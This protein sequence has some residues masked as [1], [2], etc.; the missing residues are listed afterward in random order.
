M[1]NMLHSLQR[2]SS[3]EQFLRLALMIGAAATLIPLSLY[4]YLGIFSRYGSDDYCI[5]AFYLQSNLFNA[6]IQRYM[7]ATSRYTNI[8]FTGL[9]DKLLGWYNVAIL[10][11]LMLAL[12][13][14]GLYLL[15]REIVEMLALRW[16]RL[17][18]LFLSL[19]VVY[20]SLTQAPNLYETL[21][22]RAGM[23]SHLAPLVFIPFF[24]AFLLR[25]VRRVQESKQAPSLWILVACFLIPLAIGGLSEPPTALMIT[26]LFLALLAAWWW[27]AV[28]ARRS[29][30]TLLVC[31]L[32]GASVALIIM[33]LAP[34][35]AIR[36]ETAT[37][38]L[39]ELVSR[40]IYYPFYFILDT[41]R[42]FPVPTLVSIILPTLLF[43]VKYTGTSQNLSRE[44]RVRL[45]VLIIV[46]LLL[47]Y[48][49]IAAGFAPSAYGQSYPVPRARFIGR[50][51]M[52]MAL[53]T[54]G[55]LLGILASQI[56]I[57]LQPKVLHGFATFALALLMIYPLRTTARTFAEIPVYQERA[58]AW[59][60]RESE[61]K[62]LKAKGET[63]LVVRF[64][65]E[66]R[67]QD[68]GDHRGF[69]LN[70]CAAA[71]YGVNSI[72]AVPMPDK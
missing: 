72:V 71:L 7:T 37:P 59:D 44:A 50:V 11:A 30:L 46:V 33:A 23:T 62:E 6:M 15:L 65:S 52:T 24:G 36:T 49:F 19:F 2:R 39:V 60:A 63:D 38:G 40:L 61:I 45:G 28:G 70:R 21:Y 25:Q 5:S 69:R 42:A 55:V 9:A 29:V 26:I 12:F 58:A 41:L 17:M 53:I 4:G 3:E 8:I 47:T 64:L 22:W 57:N 20:F 31:S 35:N 10:P 1:K 32:L 51:L 34:A 48:L 68:L 13:V 66:E 54:E 18:V 43:Y 67:M 27:A 56:R 16:G 14:G